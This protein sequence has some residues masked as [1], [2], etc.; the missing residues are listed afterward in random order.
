MREKVCFQRKRHVGGETCRA[1]KNPPKNHQKI[2]LTSAAASDEP[3]VVELGH[4]VLH[5]GRAVPQ[6]GAV[7]FIVARLDG[8]HCAVH[9]VAQRDH[10]E[11]HR[12]RLIGSP[13]RRQHGAHELRTARPNELAGVLGQDFGQRPLGQDVRRHF[14]VRL[15]EDV[16]LGRQLHAARVGGAAGGAGRRLRLL[17]LRRRHRRRLLLLLLLLLGCEFGGRGRPR[18]RPVV[19]VVG[20]HLVRL[21]PSIDL[22]VVVMVVQV[23]ALLEV[24]GRRFAGAVCPTMGSDRLAGCQ[25][26]YLCCPSTRLSM[27]IQSACSQK[28]VRC[29]LV[30]GEGGAEVCG[31][32]HRASERV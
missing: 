32:C 3:K 12:Q 4:L 21:G 11:G 23:P 20:R 28:C 13:V 30:E 22:E 31:D 16:Q 18:R 8:D 7:I 24:C 19:V 26:R 27:S 14:A 6:L 10:L 15:I 25:R 9:H 1:L 5:D 29:V 17:L 2:C